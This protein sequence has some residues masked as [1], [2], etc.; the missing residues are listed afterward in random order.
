M[1]CWLHNGLDLA[2]STS[3]KPL[4]NRLPLGLASFLPGRV[5]KG[6]FSGNLQ[7]KMR[8]GRTFVFGVAPRFDATDAAAGW[9]DGRS[10]APLAERTASGGS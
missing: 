6:V 4:R 10:S 2:T 8:H 9:L 5:G 1:V 7:K 3:R